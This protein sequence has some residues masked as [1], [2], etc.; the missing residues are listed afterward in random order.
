MFNL[1]T[2][3]FVTSVKRRKKKQFCNLDTTRLVY[4]TGDKFLT[5]FKIFVLVFKHKKEGRSQS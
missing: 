4:I 3:N 5:N 1:P 2:N